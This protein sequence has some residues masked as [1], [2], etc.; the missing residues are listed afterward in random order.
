MLV[1]SLVDGQDWIWIRVPKT[2]TRAY[3]QVFQMSNDAH[4]HLSY[5]ESI[6]I[7]G[8][9]GRAFSVVRNPVDRLK[10]GITHDIDEFKRIYPHR[11]YPS[12]ML[13][14]ELLC[15]VFFNI[16][17]ENCT[18]KNPLAYHVLSW[19]AGMM[20]EVLKTQS[21]AVNYPEVKVFRYENLQEFNDWIK[22]TLGLDASHV[23]I[24][25]ASDYGKYNWL[26]FS[27]PRFTELCKLIYKEDYEVYGY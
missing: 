22:N 24:N 16:L 17:G 12:W 5:K 14:I 26:D 6:K 20:A 10:S 8:D 23:E 13:D 9:V 18:I 15:D 27:N 1:K 2:A 19:E 4:T 11:Q 7:Y 21:S 25:G 3:R